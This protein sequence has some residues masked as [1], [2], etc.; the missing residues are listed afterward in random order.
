MKN[1]TFVIDTNNLISAFLFEYSTP[2]LAYDK[3]KQ[4]G[5]IV[6]SIETLNEFCDVFIRAKFDKYISFDKRLK[7]INDFMEI[8]IPQKITETIID[9]RDSKDNKFLEL[10]VAA[11]ASCIITGDKDLLV[12]HPFRGIPILNST[13]FLEKF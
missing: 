10:A 11:K 6:E 8:A 9:C 1:D 5:K 2:K 13:D 3:V 7:I 4:L 12:L